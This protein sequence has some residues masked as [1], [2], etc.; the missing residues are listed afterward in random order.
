M[1][2]LKDPQEIFKMLPKMDW[3][4]RQECITMLT[5][6]PVDAYREE[7]E[8]G[9]RN[10]DDA[11]VRNASMEVYRVLG[12]KGFPSL[13]AL[14]KESNNEVRLF[15]VNILCSIADRGTFP[16]LIDAIN[17]T[18]VNVRIAA[19]E[20]LGKIKDDRAVPVL[21]HAI[22][23]E[24]WVAMAAI[25]ALGQIGG[26][27]SLKVLY[28]CLEIPDFQELAIA[29]IGKAGKQE[30]IRYLADSLNNAQLSE[31]V[32][33]AFLE[34][35]EREHVRPDPELFMHHI[36]LLLGKL[37]SADPE[38]RK[39]VGMAISWSH[40]AGAQQ[41]VI[42]LV[43]DEDLQEHAVAALLQLGKRAVC[44]IV[45]EM[46]YST[47]PHRVLLAKTLSMLGEHDALLQFAEDHDPEV[48]TEV[49]LALASV[50]FPRALQ[51]LES[52]LN[53]PE[54]EVRMAAKKSL[55]KKT[56]GVQS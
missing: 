38:T 34:I 51:T 32:L 45:D 23:D 24:P 22:S 17:D 52:M 21:E 12:A 25:D 26:Q 48:R 5:A 8:Q 55:E 10:D 7:L 27:D 1:T 36:P 54:E 18:D 35:A 33:R 6:Y 30:S 40:I 2:I 56:K 16:L 50:V 4:K 53:D 19:A 41:C 28:R 9:I 3:W 49:A 39:A 47:G 29:A 11:D 44:G 14:L 46:R 43:R 37:Q 13:E 31:H 42:E 15:A 20:A